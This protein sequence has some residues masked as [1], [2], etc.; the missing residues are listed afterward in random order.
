M[1]VLVDGNWT[2]WQSWDQCSVTWG[3]GIT[4][5]TR[6]CT[7]PA[8]SDSGRSCIGSNKDNHSCEI[9]D[10]PGIMYVNYSGCLWVLS[11]RW[12]FRFNFDVRYRV[13]IHVN[14]LL[15][16]HT[17]NSYAITN[18]EL[19]KIEKW[20]RTCL[21]CILVNKSAQYVGTFIKPYTPMQC[22]YGY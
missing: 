17:S 21:R 1:V 4:T 20:M 8:P 2:T 3:Q 6:T 7:N 18:N 12:R 19:F 14:I 11:L 22:F 5:R 10:C 9:Q 16:K 15:C 13:V